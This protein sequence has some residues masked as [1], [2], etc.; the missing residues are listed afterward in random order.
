MKG[1]LRNCCNKER[2]TTVL[3]NISFVWNATIF[4]YEG[5]DI[6]FLWNT[7]IYLRVCMASQSRSSSSSPLWEPHLYPVYWS[8][9]IVWMNLLHEDCLDEFITWNQFYATRFICIWPPYVFRVLKVKYF[10]AGCTNSRQM[11]RNNKNEKT[12]KTFERTYTDNNNESTRIKK[13]GI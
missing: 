1:L 6:M 13:E 10:N 2:N 9:K 4:S 11:K 5:G 8:A 3:H 12:M 7:L